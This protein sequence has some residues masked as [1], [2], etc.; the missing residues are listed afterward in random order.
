MRNVY[1]VE[2]VVLDPDTLLVDQTCVGVFAQLLVLVCIA[3]SNKSIISSLLKRIRSIFRAS[4][5]IWWLPRR[6]RGSEGKMFM[7]DPLF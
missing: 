4:I 2:P 5:R 7:I 6:R 3:K 1:V